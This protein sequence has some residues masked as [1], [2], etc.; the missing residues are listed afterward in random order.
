MLSQVDVDC[1]DRSHCVV[2]IAAHQIVQ[3]AVAKFSGKLGDGPPQKWV[4]GHGKA[5][6]AG[7][8]RGLGRPSLTQS[9]LYVI[10]Q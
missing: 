4:V 3:V 7:S 1:F 9:Q 10:S 6:S 5:S 2:V 8:G